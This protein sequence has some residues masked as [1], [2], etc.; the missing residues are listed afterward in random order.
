MEE[1]PKQT[2]NSNLY[3]KKHSYVFKYG[4]DLLNLLEPKPGEKILDLGCGTGHLTNLIAA[5]GADVTGIDMSSQMIDDARKNYHN[6]KFLIG[7]ATNFNFDE[8]F[9]SVFSNAVL[10]WIKEKEKVLKCVYNTLTP[11]G[12]FVAELGGKNNIHRVESAIRTELIKRGYIR[13]AEL[14]LWHYPSV[15]EYASLLEQ[16]GF[17]VKFISYFNRDTFLNDGDSI[18]DWIEMFGKAF[19]NGIETFEKSNIIASIQESL[20]R[21]NFINNRWF[22]DYIRLRFVAAKE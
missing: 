19:F 12:K 14:N 1:L 15:G 7:D 9:H 16:T 17:T 10:H 11:G 13:N 21:T 3:D 4:E 6:L 2:W 22:V 18:T 5:S 8:K 20:K